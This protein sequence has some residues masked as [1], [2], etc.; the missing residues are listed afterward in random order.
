MKP[1]L[2][3]RN[4]KTHFSAGR[5]KTVKAVDGISFDIGEGET[6]GLVGESGC[7][8]TTTGRSILRLVEP[9]SGEIRFAGSDILRYSSAEL[10]KSRKEMQ[11]IFQDPFGS[12]HPRMTV[13]KTLE[14]PFR[15]H[16]MSVGNLAERVEELMDLVG[17]PKAHL[18]R[19]PHQFSG[20]QRQ[21]IGIARAL[22]LRPKFIVCDEPVSALDVSIQSQIINLLCDL[23]E[24]L[25]LTY[26]FIAHGLHVVKYISD[27]VGV[28]YMGKLVEL[29]DSRTL[30]E[31]PKHPYT[32]ALLSA[33]PVPETGR[34]SERVILQ[35]DVPSPIDPPS[36][37][38]FC[39]RCPAAMPV[40]R[41]L[42]PEWKLVGDRHYAACHLYS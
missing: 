2:E 33:I 32:Q 20:G 10:R 11:I 28:M 24:R 39:S 13:R 31:T 5:K 9:T 38:R 1:L 40:C 3:V 19:Y 23:Q 41:E 26:L 34:R 6:L 15:I 36:G 25:G 21:R 12:L 22:A 27:R 4:L 29:A 30:Y 14:E 7:G 18:E 8:K 37:C 35:G 16:S 42:D 17:L